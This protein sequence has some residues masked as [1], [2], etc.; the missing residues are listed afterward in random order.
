MA[1]YYFINEYGNIF[2]NSIVTKED[3]DAADDGYLSIIDT[4][5]NTE[6]YMNEWVD[7]KKWES[8]K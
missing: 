2:T 8:E 6:Y 7:I 5:S 4:V 3:K 1:R